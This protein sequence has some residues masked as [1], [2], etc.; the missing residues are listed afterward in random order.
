MQA[1]R[2]LLKRLV[3][4]EASERDEGSIVTRSLSRLATKWAVEQQRCARHDLEST[5]ASKLPAVPTALRRILARREGT[6]S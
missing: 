3:A 5:A 4:K 6:L 2:S 1:D